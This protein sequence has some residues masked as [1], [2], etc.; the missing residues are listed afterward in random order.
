MPPPF[1]NLSVVTILLLTIVLAFT[2]CAPED[3]RLTADKESCS[4]M[5]HLPGSAEFQQ[6]MQDLNDRRCATISRKGGSRHEAN[7]DC[8][9]L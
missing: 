4:S 1:R 5:G 9:K 3:R 7:L 2:G 6:C 8:T